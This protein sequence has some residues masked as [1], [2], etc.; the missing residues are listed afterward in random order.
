MVRHDASNPEA[1][2]D[3][4]IAAASIADADAPSRRAFLTR[5]GRRRESSPLLAADY[6]L[7]LSR[8]AMAC[9]FELFLH[10]SDRRFLARAQA[11]LEQVDVLEAQLSVFRESS[12]LSRINRFAA[13]GPVPVSPNLYSLLR[14]A[15]EIGRETAGAYDV[16]TGALIR[17]WGFLRRSGRVPD[18][19]ALERARTASGWE[20]VVFHDATQTI[21]FDVPDVEINLGSIGKGYALDCIAARL[22]AAGVCD[23]LLHAGFRSVLAA[24]CCGAADGWSIALADGRTAGHRL[25]M[26]MLRDRALSTSG[27]GQQSFEADGRRY[28]HILDPRSG[29]PSDAC[30]QSSAVA[31]S[32][33]AS[34]ALSTAFFVMQDADVRTYCTRHSEVGRATV[35]RFEALPIVQGLELIPVES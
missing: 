6:L 33:A 5:A 30:V 19:A 21:A 12:E 3:T 25:G 29:V 28:G 34:E 26:V 11:A 10:S 35:R 23:F 15:R 1:F 31:P 32:A 20:H 14:F 22:R 9:T 4:A 27:I 7:Q 13:D 18:S 8:T 2:L 16:T 17:C 24:G